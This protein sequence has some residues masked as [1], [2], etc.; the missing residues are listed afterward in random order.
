MDRLIEW[1]ETY[2]A[3]CIRANQLLE[4]GYSAGVVCGYFPARFGFEV[5]IRAAA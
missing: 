5:I 1:Y 2:K 3:A 4:H